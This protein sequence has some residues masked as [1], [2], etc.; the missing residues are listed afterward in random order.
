MKVPKESTVSVSCSDS[1]LR[2]RRPVSWI[3]TFTVLPASR[4]LLYQ[5][6]W[7]ICNH[8]CITQVIWT[9]VLLVS[10]TLFLSPFLVG[11]MER[12]TAGYNWWT[13]C[14]LLRFRWVLWRGQSKCKARFLRDSQFVWFLSGF[15]H[16]IFEI[17]GI[18]MIF[19]FFYQKKIKN[20]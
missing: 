8:A 4:I 6:Q 19:F 15:F 10:C 9:I 14:R 16:H 7:L 3:S 11:C 1:S 20:I 12:V 2:R 18:R 5:Y 17:C 13:V